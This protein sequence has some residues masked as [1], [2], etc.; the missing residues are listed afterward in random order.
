MKSAI[1]IVAL[2]LAGCGACDEVETVNAPPVVA[3]A[4]QPEPSKPPVCDS[5]TFT[6]CTP[7]ADMEICDATTYIPCA[8]PTWIPVVVRGPVEIEVCAQERGCP[9]SPAP[10][11]PRQ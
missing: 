6:N 9:E 2:I 5:N 11:I 1:V 10:Y 4:P 8:Q 7:P 3:P